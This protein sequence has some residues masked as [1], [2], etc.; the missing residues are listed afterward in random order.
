MLAGLG[1]AAGFDLGKINDL[2]GILTLL[3]FVVFVPAYIWWHRLWTSSFFNH[4]PFGTHVIL[5]TV[6]VVCCMLWKGNN[7]GSVIKQCAW[8]SPS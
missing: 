7:V 5:G 3:W 4:L 8:W 2:N 1:A 6:A